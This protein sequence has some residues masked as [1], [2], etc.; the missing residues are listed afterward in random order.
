VKGKPDQLVGLVS[1]S[2]A[3]SPPA[4]VWPLVLALVRPLVLALV[5]PLV[6][7]LVRPLVALALAL[8]TG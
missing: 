5:R 7:A 8:A 1:E 2:L 6:L 4:P 3:V